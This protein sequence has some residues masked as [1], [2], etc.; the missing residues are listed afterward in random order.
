MSLLALLLWSCSM[1]DNQAPT[2][3]QGAASILGAVSTGFSTIGN[4]AASQRREG[5]AETVLGLATGQ[6]EASATQAVNEAEANAALAVAAARL[7]N[8]QRTMRAAQSGQ[9]PQP[10]GNAGTVI[11]VVLAAGA[12]G[13]A[14]WWY[15]GSRRK[16]GR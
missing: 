12:V 5:Q 13:G 7:A 16:G 6:R 2:A 8:E 15:F 11:A 10:S 4:Y 3:G 1:S 9:Q 14:A